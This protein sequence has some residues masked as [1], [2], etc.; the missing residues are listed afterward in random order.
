MNNYIER[1]DNHDSNSIVGGIMVLFIFLWVI[2]GII[3]FI[4]SL[5]CFTRSGTTTDKFIGLILAFLFG[6]FYFIFF[7]MSGYCSK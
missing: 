7:S 4:T 2:I 3:A 6:P 5:Y 1:Y